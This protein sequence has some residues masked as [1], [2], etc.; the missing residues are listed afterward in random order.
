MSKKNIIIANWKMNNSF[1]E[2]EKWVKEF[3]QELD[4][5][6]KIRAHELPRIVLC[7]PAVLIDHIDGLL[8]EEK[9]DQLEEAFQ[10]IDN[11]PQSALDE[12]KLENRDVKLGGQDCSY[13]IS[14][15]YTGDTSA[16][17]LK[18]AGCEYVILGHSE[19][20]ANHHESNQ[21]IAQKVKAA[22]SQK[23]IPILCVG[24]SQKVRDS[25]QYLDFIK[26]QVENCIP[27][28]LDI[29]KLII[30]YEPIWSIGTGTIPTTEQIA[31]IAKFIREVVGKTANISIN[32]V[33]ILYGG[34]TNKKN[35]AAILAIAGVNGL[36]VGGASLDADEFFEMIK[37]A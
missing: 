6:K 21:M 11:I 25:K 1:D 4:A 33:Q 23:L 15:A 32:N 10:D 8:M 20:R 2:T 29:Q 14:G 35:A 3:S 19:R 16:A 30:A 36:L 9:I 5:Y 7:P 27:K 18:D 22:V 26:E 17:V 34:S 28:N 13:E 37:L 31:E 24:E 12:F